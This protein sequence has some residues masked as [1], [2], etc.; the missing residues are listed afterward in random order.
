VPVR[1]ARRDIVRGLPARGLRRAQQSGGSRH[2]Q[3]PAADPITP[4]VGELGLAP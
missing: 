4:A 3:D 2:A 1:G